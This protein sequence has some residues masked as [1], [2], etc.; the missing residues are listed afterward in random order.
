MT[1]TERNWDCIILHDVDFLPESD[2]AP[3][4]CDATPMRLNVLCS[5]YRYKYGSPYYDYFG[6]VTSI[7]ADQFKLVNGFSNRFQGWG[8]EDDDFYNR[9]RHQNIRPKLMDQA[10]ALKIARCS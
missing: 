2:Y 7:K 5:N 3:Y 6:G 1:R 4:Y 10:T 8:G 9:I